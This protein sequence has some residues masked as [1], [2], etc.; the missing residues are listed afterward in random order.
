MMKFVQWLWS[1]RPWSKNTSPSLNDVDTQ[2]ALGTYT[3][4]LICFY[5]RTSSHATLDLKEEI[6]I[7]AK[8]KRDACVQYIQRSKL[9]R[10]LH[11]GI[12]DVLAEDRQ[13]N[14]AL[15]QEFEW[16]YKTEKT[17]AVKL[18]VMEQK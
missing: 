11:P 2:L 1:L 3:K 13:F 14:S 8:D 9:A 4:Y 10:K 12:Y 7:I 6:T 5:W 15:S 18:V 17:V 16:T